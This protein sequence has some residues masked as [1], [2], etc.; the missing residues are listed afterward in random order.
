[1]TAARMRLSVLFI[2][3]LLPIGAVTTGQA[4]ADRTQP[5]TGAIQTDEE[6]SLMVHY[7]EV[8]TPE[9]DAT[10]DVLSKAHGVVFGEPVLELG[11]ARTAELADGGR[12]GVRAPLRETERPVVRPYVLVEDIDAALQAAVEAGAEAALP[13]MEIPGQGTISIYILGGIEHGLWQE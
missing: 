12:I 3:P 4:G 9:V 6:K 1:M 2:A 11:N 13:R 8:V 5:E 7:L 10:C